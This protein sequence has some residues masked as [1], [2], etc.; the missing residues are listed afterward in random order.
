[1]E[2]LGREVDQ[3]HVSGYGC[4]V[5]DYVEWSA[6]EANGRIGA[7]RAIESMIGVIMVG[8][9]VWLLSKWRHI[10]EKNGDADHGDD[11]VN[12][13]QVRRA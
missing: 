1:M 13:A 9:D 7:V 11:S 2:E 10:G 5:G 6:A 3:A 8:A 12:V 4:G